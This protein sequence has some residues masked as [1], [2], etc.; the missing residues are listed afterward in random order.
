MPQPSSSSHRPPS[1]LIST[2]QPASPLSS[3]E[4]HHSPSKSPFRYVQLQ[5]FQEKLP[6][7]LE[8]SRPSTPVDHPLSPSRVRPSPPIFPPQPS[9][10]DTLLHYPTPRHALRQVPTFM[11]QYRSHP[12][13]FHIPDRLKP[14]LGIGS[15]VITSIG[16]LLA[17]AF[18]KK[19]VFTGLDQLSH[20]LQS[21]GDTGYAILFCLIFI[22][23]IPPFPLYSTL[24]ILS[25]YTFGTWIGA[26]ISYAAA[27]SGAVVVF[28]VSRRYLRDTMS[29]LL[30]H[31]ASLKRVVRAI[32][33]RPKLLLLIRI[34]PYPY[35][36]MNVLLAASHTL[37][38]STY[39]WC[40]ALSLVKVVIHTSVGSGIH[41]FAGY[42]RVVVPEGGGDSGG[43]AEEKE[44]G[45]GK[46]WT[47]IGIA[48]CVAILVYLSYVAR[49]A[50]DEE[51]EDEGV[52]RAEEGR[53]YLSLEAEMREVPVAGR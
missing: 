21:L 31:T 43:Q 52:A 10:H 20:Y 42:H 45:L 15:W 29:R 7:E 25:G 34:A 53:G 48:L 49:K 40:T 3:S 19:E 39:F 28:L 33:K 47:V 23:T 14:W 6:S 24:I 50:V 44:N 9:R 27:L 35:N 18:W 2:S 5:Q 1:L 51:L 13:P 12:Q 26:I 17:I 37:T 36:L 38:F 46:A 30:S 8:T 16:F 32:E 22:T 11:P 41:N 4:Q